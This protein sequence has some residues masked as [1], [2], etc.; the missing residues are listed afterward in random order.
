MSQSTKEM[1]KEGK[2][3][4]FLINMY[5]NYILYLFMFHFCS[6]SKKKTVAILRAMGCT[7][8]PVWRASDPGLLYRN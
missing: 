8:N 7:Q 5:F 4:L 2:C 6:Y 3:R 1:L